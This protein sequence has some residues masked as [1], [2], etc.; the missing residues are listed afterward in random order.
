M[1]RPA[2]HLA[3][4]PKHLSMDI[5][6]YKQAKVDPKIFL[7]RLGVEFQKF[8][9]FLASEASKIRL[10]QSQQTLQPPTCFCVL[11]SEFRSRTTIDIEF[12]KV[13]LCLARKQDRDGRG[14]PIMG[15]RLTQGP[16]DDHMEIE[17]Y[18]RQNFSANS[19]LFLHGVV[20]SV[21]YHFQPP[22][23]RWRSG[24]RR[25]VVNRGETKYLQASKT[26]SICVTSAQ[27]YTEVTVY[28]QRWPVPWG[29]SIRSHSLTP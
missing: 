23:S 19:H 1:T 20:W 9:C 13:L 22:R 6:K 17:W 2:C 24:A 21:L 12:G 5:Q 14:E 10:T 8:Q 27:R 4:R 25:P 15:A 11:L 28:C 3:S 7:V 16:R 29:I 26:E 18:E